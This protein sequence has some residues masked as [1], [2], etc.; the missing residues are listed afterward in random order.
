MTCCCP[1]QTLTGNIQGRLDLAYM[2]HGMM[3]G[4]PYG[5]SSS[6][7]GIRSTSA[8]RAPGAQLQ[9]DQEPQEMYYNALPAMHNIKQHEIE[10]VGRHILANR[11][12]VEALCDPQ[13]LS[14]RTF[15]GR[16]AV[17]GGCCWLT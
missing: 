13:V 4:K 15:A 14:A 16:F 17:S 7:A 10:D 2:V 12:F 11:P 8:F 5:P 9:L 1:L 6:V 3:Q